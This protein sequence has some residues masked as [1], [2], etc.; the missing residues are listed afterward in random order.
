MNKLEK[1]E[2]HTALPQATPVRLSDYTPGIFASVSS[3]KGMK[4]AIS[5]G[6]VRVNGQVAFTSKYINGGEV[7][8]L[9]KEQIDASLP[10]L[11]LDL[12]VLH[13]DAQL[14]IIYKPSGI[15]VSG[16]KLK[17]IANALPHVLEESAEADAL[18]R[19]QPAHRLDF[20]TSGVL[21]IG[22]TSGTLTA[23]NKLF[24]S[25]SIQKTY[26]AITIGKMKSSGEIK[27]E[28]KGK[29][30]ETTYK[31]LQEI[32]SPKFEFLNYVELKPTTG[33][34]H[35]L[36]IHMAEL[37][38]P[39]LGDQTYGL[40]GKISQGKGLYLHASEIAFIHP[41]TGEP[42]HIKAELPQKFERL[43]NNKLSNSDN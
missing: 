32:P 12:Q 17:T 36:R 9:Y 10:V 24:E 1:I 13:E 38:N 30:A 2:T 26:L 35:Q 3:K 22:K 42:L 21:L 34:R 28:I 4:K 43:L 8:D 16:N 19:P 39:I 6:L 5:K 11:E 33:R 40:N 25:K 15:V 7:I 14:A 41:K 18:S 23:L 37:G 31:V 20:P 27:T 29:K